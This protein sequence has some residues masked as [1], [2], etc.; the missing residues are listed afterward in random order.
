MTK[1]RVAIMSI[2]TTVLIILLLAGCYAPITGTVV[3]AVT[4]A[5]IEGAVVMVE[6][7]KTH[8]IGE[9]W[10]E[11]YKVAETATD[12]DGKF[13]LPGCYSP[14]VSEPNVTIYKQGYVAWS[15]RWI[16]PGRRNR[17]DFKW[18]GDSVFKLD[19]FKKKY[20]YSD[21]TDFIRASIN[22]SMNLAAKGNIYDAFRWE[23]H[24]ASEEMD[25][26]RKQ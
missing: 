5:P 2:I 15:S 23:D 9:H 14:F 24:L 21:H 7:T 3:D 12:K 16:F 26:L 18:G 6:W 20:T 10:T 4:N 11:S 17:T 8:G 22:S 19:V 13:T 1:K 25:R